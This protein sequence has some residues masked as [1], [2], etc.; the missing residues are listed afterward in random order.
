MKL[1]EMELLKGKTT[2]KKRVGRGIG[3]GKGGHTSGKGAK[4]QKARSGG[5]KPNLGF[6]GGQVPLYKR[7]PRLNGFTV[8]GKVAPTAVP[9][10]I[11]NVFEDGEQ[12][13]PR[14]LKELRLIRLLPKLGIKVLA[15]GELKKKVV[16]KGFKISASALQVIEKAGAKVLK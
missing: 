12:V 13:T 10:S 3:S 16:L 9:V 4:G 8:H 6:E 11:F 14:I 1:N 2:P 5:S 7:M 15:T